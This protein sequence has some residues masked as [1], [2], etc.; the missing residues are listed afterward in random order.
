M[1]AAAAGAAT[2]VRSVGLAPPLPAS[3][4]GPA[5]ADGVQQ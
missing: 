5:V 3:L 1:S 4:W 2:A